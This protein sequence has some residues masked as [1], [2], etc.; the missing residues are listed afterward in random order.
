LPAGTKDTPSMLRFTVAALW[1]WS[2]SALSLAQGWPQ[3][4][5]EAFG[6]PRRLESERRPAPP[7]EPLPQTPLGPALADGGPRPEIVP[8]V[9]PLVAFAHAY[10]ARSIVIDSSGRT[11]YFVLE[12]GQAYAYPVGVG[13]EGFGWTGTEKI[14]RKQAWPD[15]HPPE[16]MR[17][18]DPTLP[19]KMTGGVK[20]PLGAKAIYLGNTL[21]RI[22]GTNEP[23][24]IGRAASSGC[25]R[26]LNGHVVDLASR[27]GVGTT[28]TVV[29]SLPPSLARIVAQ[30]VAG[31]V[32]PQTVVK[33]PPVRRPHRVPDDLFGPSEEGPPRDELAGEGAGALSRPF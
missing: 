10:P 9:P 15:W 8:Q 13:R 21:Y 1:L 12:G 4:A 26:M 24:S 33:A 22:H 2:L 17:Q 18:R 14:S 25:F 31:T 23:K 27:V 11:L 5:E 32:P 19:E 28:V 6:A 7:V 29:R 30:Q 16:E 3:W 20:N